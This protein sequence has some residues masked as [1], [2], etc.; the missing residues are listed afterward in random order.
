MNFVTVR[1]YS[2]LNLKEIL[3]SE[4]YD[5]YLVENV[6]INFY[7]SNKRR[8]CTTLFFKFLIKDMI[9][10]WCFSYLFISFFNI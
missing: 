10:E 3:I 5:N 2:I 9:V 6:C 4:N 7:A 8:S 1:K